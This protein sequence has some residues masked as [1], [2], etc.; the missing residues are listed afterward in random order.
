[1]GQYRDNYQINSWMCRLYITETAY[2][3]LLIPILFKNLKK[4][5]YLDCDTIVQS[6]IAE[7]F[8]IDLKDNIVA[9][10]RDYHISQ[11]QKDKELYFPGFW[12]YAHDI[13][14]IKDISCYFNSGVMVFDIQKMNEKDIFNQFL[15]VAKIN[16]RYFHD[17]NILNSVLQYN[18]MHLDPSW[19]IQVNMGNDIYIQL[20]SSQYSSPKILHFCSQRKPWNSMLGK[21]TIWNAIWWKYA[22]KSIYYEQIL[23]SYIEENTPQIIIKD[24]L[25]YHHLY[26][27]YIFYCIKQYVTRGKRRIRYKNKKES[28]HQRIQ[29]VKKWM[30]NIA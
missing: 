26:I 15:N 18:I 23:L 7:L 2:Y 4:I 30:K 8:Q 28:Y 19:N 11:I 17:Q 1:M 10:V 22:K 29:N 24:A 9:A 13:L 3:R 5:I 6:D 16:N 12:N 20:L 25:K 14:C 21:E 27:S